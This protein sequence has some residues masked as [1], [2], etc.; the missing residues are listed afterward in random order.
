MKVEKISIK[1]IITSLLLA[2]GFVVITLSLLMT[3]HSRQIAFS[4]QAASMSRVIEVVAKQV[5]V[6]LREL[7]I[8]LG[9]GTQRDKLFRKQV[10]KL[11]KNPQDGDL[12]DKVVAH[13]DDQFLQT[14]TNSGLITP[15]RL[16]LFSKDFKL[17]AESTK[18]K[19]WTLPAGLPQFIADKAL[20]RE[21]ADRLKALSGIGKSGDNLFY[22]VLLPVGGLSLRGYL[23]VV[24]DPTP[25][26]QAI[27]E[28][29][30]R[31]L[32]ITSIGNQVLFQSEDWKD[33]QADTLEVAYTLPTEKG[34]PGLGL[35][36]LED[37]TALNSETGK[38]AMTT[39]AS[40]A[41][42][43]VIGLVCVLVIL[44]KSLFRPIHKLVTAMESC[45]AGD[46]T[47]V[48][49]TTGLKELHILGEK[50]LTLVAS[51]RNNVTSIRGSSEQLTQDAKQLL[52]TAGNQETST[53]QQQ[54][55]IEQLAAAMNELSTSAQEVATHAETTADA[56]TQ[57]SEEARRGEQIVEVTAK[58]IHDVADEIEQASQII[59]QL[60]SNTEKIGSVLD[61][62][63]AVAE[64]TNLLALNAAIEAARA[65]DHG[66]GFAVVADE[67]RSLAQRTQESTTEIQLIIEQLQDGA[68]KGVKAMEGSR[69][70]T[71]NSVEQA[72]L[73]GSSLAN[74]SKAVTGI[75]E[76]NTQIAMAAK[77]QSSA[78]DSL[79]QGLMT[80]T[81]LVNEGA[82]EVLHTTEVSDRL[83]DVA[84]TLQAQVNNFHV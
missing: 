50:L 75:T 34:E 21:G 31:P 45:S 24:S 38:M 28:V 72:S 82:E 63:R 74:I 18:G 1:A 62:I 36:L 7:A 56:T 47:V 84:E 58:A 39:V 69:E 19:N 30:Q 60:A 54:A 11:A 3:N 83:K 2:L 68:K 20:E 41:L 26:L 35:Q 44:R 25:N 70:K 61:V 43:I 4:S 42:V 9:T 81:Q 33:G 51:L 15:V 66:R 55:E 78:S 12:R 49:E 80:I 8:E 64:Q 57:T 16:R 76:M 27:S 53:Q 48:P 73:A 71:K 10:K 23:E 79:N 5:F 29:T 17:I 67:V 65:G 6:D 46:L 77:E 32:T 37:V 13:L 22:S 40:F 14:I 52:T 59:H